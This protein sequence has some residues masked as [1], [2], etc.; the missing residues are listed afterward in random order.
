ML[1]EE[2][3]IPYRVEKINMRSYGEKPGWYLR[4]VPSGLLPAVSLD[5][6]LIT[7]SLVIMQLLDA[8]FG[9][10]RRA[11][12]PPAGSEALERAE[13]L[14]QLERKL[15]GWWC[16]SIFRPGGGR[17]EIGFRETLD[18]VDRALGETPG[19]WFL[20]P[21]PGNG[22][23]PGGI[24]NADC[25][26]SLVDLTYVPHLERMAASAVYWRGLRIR[27]NSRWP[28]IDRWFDALELRP[29]Y[30]ASKSDFYTH[31]R[32]IPPQYGDGF[33][34]DGAAV[35]AAAAAVAGQDGSWS[36]P[37]PSLR[38]PDTGPGFD[39]L[40]PLEPVLPSNDP[41]VELACQEAALRLIRNRAAVTRFACRGAGTSSGWSNRPGR[42]LLSD[43]DAVPN[44]DVASDVSLVLRAVAAALLA[45]ETTTAAAALS[46]AAVAASAVAKAGGGG[47]DATG[48]A[49]RAAA[50]AQCVEYLRD[51]VG[52]PRDM[53]YPAARQL[54]AHLNWA[55]DMV[56]AAPANG[57]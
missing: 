43:P 7:E 18:E 36:L 12:L 37:L 39:G 31:V 52:V 29:S 38:G 10:P 56:L 2:K 16:Q 44:D 51:R 23:S 28:N 47:G 25:G 14:L 6:R 4:L 27:G 30:M 53:P 49:G 19:P 45:G 46:T 9:A 35:D 5:G 26:P 13:E 15:F 40:G 21:Y 57:P 42:A 55:R 22:G 20:G 48:V 8:T 17:S 54:R 50:V 1:L 33:F 41:G 3:Q 24:A 11:M 34:G 32:D